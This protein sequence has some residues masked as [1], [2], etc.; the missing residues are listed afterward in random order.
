V[1]GWLY[2]NL[3]LPVGCDTTPYARKNL[4]RIVVETRGGFPLKHLLLIAFLLVGSCLF[5]VGQ[6][7]GIAKELIAMENRYN[8]ALLRADWKS[9]ESLLAGD[10]VFNNADGSV[11][12]KPDTISSLRSGEIKFDS[13]AMSDVTVQ[14]FGGVGVVSGKLVEKAR[15]KSSDL[16]GSYRFLDVWVKRDGR[17]QNV[18]GQE[19]RY[20]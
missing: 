4:L 10:L 16:S 12:H 7:D 11:S 9:L 13:I 2:R 19:T 20:K 1:S 18:A 17:W 6:K 5:A 15:Y 3:C 14:G 8:D